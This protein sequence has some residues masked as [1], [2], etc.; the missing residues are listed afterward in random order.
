MVKQNTAALEESIE[1]L[2]V[3]FSGGGKKSWNEPS[4]CS[5]KNVLFQNPSCLSWPL[6]IPKS[7]PFLSYSTLR[8]ARYLTEQFEVSSG[9]KC[10]Q[11]IFLKLK[12]VMLNS[13]QSGK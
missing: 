10:L 6:D 5:G 13:V 1:G 3:Y 9:L 7:I 12:Q 4:N 2:Q 11:S 8:S